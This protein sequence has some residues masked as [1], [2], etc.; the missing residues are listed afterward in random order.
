GFTPPSQGQEADFSPGAAA[1]VPTFDPAPQASFEPAGAPA[2]APVQGNQFFPEQASA[3]SAPSAPS[4]PSVPS[5][6]TPMSTG[7]F[8]PVAE[9]RGFTGK[10][11]AGFFQA[12]RKPTAEPAAPISA[13]NDGL[14]TRTPEVELPSAEPNSALILPETNF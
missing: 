4:S 1:N 6:T 11:A 3:P 13:A 8:E 7:G 9:P 5:T 2:F 10:A 14:P 12:T